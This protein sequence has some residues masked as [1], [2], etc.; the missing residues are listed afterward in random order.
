MISRKLMIKAGASFVLA[1]LAPAAFPHAL[2][3]KA[4]PP[5]GG[6]VSASPTEIRLKFSEGVEPAFSGI[7]LTNEAGASVSL[8]KA[9]VDP[10]DDATLVAPISHPLP[11]GVYKVVWHAVSVDTHK[12]QGSFEFTVKP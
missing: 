12:T 9:S 1:L 6:V 11:A 3:K 2:L 8:G 10:A 4:V 7:T 5:V